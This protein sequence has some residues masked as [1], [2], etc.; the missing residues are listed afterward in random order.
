MHCICLKQFV[1]TVIIK[2]KSILNSSLRKNLLLSIARYYSD[3]EHIR[4]SRS[5]SRIEQVQRKKLTSL[6]KIAQKTEYGEKHSLNEAMTWEDFNKNVP[7]IDYSDIEEMII[8]QKSE[9][10]PVISG[11]KCRY[12]LPTS[13]ITDGIKWIPCTDLFLSELDSAT[14]QILVY[15]M[16]R[17]RDVFSGKH[18]WSVPWYPPGIREEMRSTASDEEQGYIKNKIKSLFMTV[19]EKVS[20]IND[21]EDYC[22]ANMAYIAA[23]KNI[24]LISIWNPGVALNLLDQLSL[25]R[26]ELSDILGSGSWGDRSSALSFLP[27]P[28]SSGAAKLLRQWKGTLSEQFFQELWPEMKMISSWDTGSSQVWIRELTRLFPNATFQ[29]KGLWATE[30]VVTIPFEGKYALAVTS[31]F[32]EFLDLET[33][34]IIPSWGLKKGQTVSPVISTGSGLFRYNL[35][36]RLEVTGFIDQCPCFSYEGRVAETNIAG[37]QLSSHLAQKVLN[38]ISEH[39]TVNALSLLA[40]PRDYTE[41]TGPYYL[42][43]CDLGAE[44]VTPEKISSFAE[45]RLISHLHYK[46]ARDLNQLGPVKVIMHPKARQLYQNLAAHSGRVIGTMKMEPLVN[47][48]NLEGPAYREILDYTKA[49]S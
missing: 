42:I 13:G 31:H 44:G 47:W 19:P 23:E 48:E 29:G 14:S 21:Y 10:S 15:F 41:N 9:N 35:H 24:T 40:I 30:G 7:L 18:F 12:Y 39:F 6:L 46:L 33:N 11:S 34:R 1:R 8:R 28:R 43:L 22:L 17:N 38:E 26:E 16:K 4:F 37:E 27:C 25:H 49:R 2:M 3:Y 45:E 20:F 5:L 36:D 32:Y